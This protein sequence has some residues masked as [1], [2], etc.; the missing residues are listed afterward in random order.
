M[1]PCTG[2][3]PLSLVIDDL[4][5]ELER[6]RGRC[7]RRFP[8]GTRCRSCGERSLLALG[9][10]ISDPRCY[11]DRVRPQE[12]HHVCGHGQ[13]PVVIDIS[14]NVHLICKEGERIARVVRLFDAGLCPPCL[15]GIGLLVST[16]LA[17][18]EAA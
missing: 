2:A 8:A 3:C 5:V 18:I 15:Y 9:A 12:G 6:S 1:T 11:A 4:R 10:S 17:R 7:H 14:S 16:E 13:G